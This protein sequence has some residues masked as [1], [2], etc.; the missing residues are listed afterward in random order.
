MALILLKVKSAQ[1]IK[2]IKDVLKAGWD[3][4][5]VAVGFILKILSILFGFRV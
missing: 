5:G 3:N 1:D 2:D 4:A